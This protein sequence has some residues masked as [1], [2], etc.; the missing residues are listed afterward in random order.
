MLRGINNLDH[1]RV[2]MDEVRTLYES[3]G[4]REPLIYM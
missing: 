4:L 2:R 3:I 1:N